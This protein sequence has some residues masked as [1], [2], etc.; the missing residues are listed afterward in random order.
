MLLIIMGVFCVGLKESTQET[1]EISSSDLWISVLF[2]VLTGL[3][4]SMNS[5]IF[6]VCSELRPM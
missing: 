1:S 5:V 6:K 2:A 4:I 3:C